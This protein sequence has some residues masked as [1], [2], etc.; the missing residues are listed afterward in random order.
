MGDSFYYYAHCCGSLVSPHKPQ[1][2]SSNQGG[3]STCLALG[4]CQWII[5]MCYLSFSW[6]HTL[7]QHDLCFWIIHLDPRFR[8]L[9]VFFSKCVF[10]FPFRSIVV[11]VIMPLQHLKHMVPSLLSLQTLKWFQLGK[12]VMLS[13]SISVHKHVSTPFALVY[14]HN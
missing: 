2:Y 5:P 11:L 8:G 12:H 13:S 7:C 9:W 6:R 10:P 4:D 3:L 1:C 14:S